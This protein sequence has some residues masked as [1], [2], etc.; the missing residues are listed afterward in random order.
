MSR[1][2]SIGLGNMGGLMAANL[3]KAQH[4]VTG[5]DLAPASLAAAEQARLTG[6]TEQRM[7]IADA[8]AATS[9][10]PH[11]RRAIIQVTQTGDV[12]PLA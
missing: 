9:R 7:N 2:A 8:A 1:I 6:P 5:F 11:R 4:Q 10:P 12:E 3:V